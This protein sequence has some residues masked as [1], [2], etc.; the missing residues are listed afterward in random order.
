MMG[1][2]ITICVVVGLILATSGVVKAELTLDPFG[3]TGL[4]NSISHLF[5]IGGV[6]SFQNISLHVWIDDN[7]FAGPLDG[8]HEQDANRDYVQE[9]PSWYG[10][11]T[12]D[13]TYT[14]GWGDDLY[15]G[16][17]G[18]RL[19]FTVHCNDSSD[20]FYYDLGVHY[21]SW[22]TN[23]QPGT[24]YWRIGCNGMDD[25]DWYVMNSWGYVADPEGH[26][27]PLKQAQPPIPAPGAILL[28]SIGVGIVGWLRRMDIRKL[29]W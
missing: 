16:T 8:F 17:S 15:G 11:M 7:T 1:K 2:I 13:G 26:D 29:N 22:G 9:L 10:L 3:E 4:E 25:P 19:A 14:Q 23:Q 24:N 28:G 5:S 12:S 18:A 27:P 21:T 20:P 6:T